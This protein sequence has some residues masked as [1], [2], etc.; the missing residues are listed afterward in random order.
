MNTKR[1]EKLTREV[2]KLFEDM[3]D[4]MM[5]DPVLEEIIA[6]CEKKSNTDKKKLR[7]KTALQQR[8][9]QM[10]L[11]SG[12]KSHITGYNIYRT[13]C[14][15]KGKTPT[16]ISKEWNEMSEKKKKRYNEKAK[17]RREEYNNENVQSYDIDPA[18]T[19]D[20]EV[21]TSVKKVTVKFSK[22]IR[23]DLAEEDDEVSS[24][25]EKVD[26]KKTGKG[27]T[28]KPSINKSKE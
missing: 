21:D 14:K 16:E 25:F 28:K 10:Q 4:D 15:G 18:D 5:T 22:K 12:K 26:M 7:I 9:E 2:N 20:T 13:E 17:Q 27:K 3:I 11:E 8:F 6:I 23:K 19:T 24:A 1:S